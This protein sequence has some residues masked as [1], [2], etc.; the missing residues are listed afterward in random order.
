MAAK[1]NNAFTLQTGKVLQARI[2]KFG[3]SREALYQEGHEIALQCAAHYDTHGDLTLAARFL[4][5]KIGNKPKGSTKYVITDDFPGVCGSLRKQMV[6][7][8]TAFT[9][10]RFNGDGMIYR[11]NVKSESYQAHL[12][13][14]GG[15]SENNRA[16]NVAKG[17]ENPW[18]TLDGAV[19]DGSRTLDL[20]NLIAM[21]DAI[22]KRVE[23]A[24]A[25]DAERAP[26]EVT[27]TY[28][29]DQLD[30]MRALVNAVSKAKADV[31]ASRKVNVVDLEEARKARKVKAE[32][33]IVSPD[34]LAATGDIVEAPQAANG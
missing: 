20:L 18:Y 25:D 17:A 6:A 34:A 7:W 11:M 26:G 23:K 1:T 12:L 16:V 28:A 8:F 30:D 14:I 22:S 15:L 10:L 19:R 27:H 29:P 33:A 24:V 4:G 3:A 2:N 13:A 32:A 5:G 9:D 21:V 31:L